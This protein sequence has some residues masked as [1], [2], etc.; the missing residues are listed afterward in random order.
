MAIAAKADGRR[1]IYSLTTPP[2]K[3]LAKIAISHAR[4]GGLKGMSVPKLTGSS[5]LPPCSIDTATIASRGS[6]LL[7]NIVSPSHGSSKI[8]AAINTTVAAPG[9]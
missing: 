7:L 2:L 9:I 4:N 1:E 6:P 5:Q 8:A 3:S